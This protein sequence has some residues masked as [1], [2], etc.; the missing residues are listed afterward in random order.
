MC[1]VTRAC[2]RTHTHAPCKPPLENLTHTHASAHTRA[3]THDTHSGELYPVETDVRLCDELVT[4]QDVEVDMDKDV[5]T[6]LDTGKTY[7]L[8]PIGEV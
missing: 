4:G 3:H 8:K 6:V 7:S 2:G 5:L 1:I